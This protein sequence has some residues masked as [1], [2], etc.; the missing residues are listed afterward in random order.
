MLLGFLVL[1]A[2][3]GLAIWLQL[4]L[5]TGTAMTLI[6]VH[7]YTGLLGLPVLA[8]KAVAGA[9]SWRR[10]ATRPRTPPSGRLD[11]L[12]TA[13][14]VA[15]V[16]ALYGSGVTM[17]GNWGVL[18]GGTLK[19]VHLWAAVAGV[20]ILTYHLWRFLSRARA[21]VG[22]AIRSAEPV[23][24][25]G[26]RHLL[27][28]GGL[29]LVGWGAVR[30]GAGSVAELDRQGPNDFPVTL[31]S[32]GADQPDPATWRMRI[33]GEVQRPLV[34][35]LADLRAG[36][37]ERHRYSLDC[38]L[39]WSATRTWGG[40]PLRDLLRTAGASS[41]LISVVVRS[42]T[43]YRVALLREQVEDPR[44]MVAWEVDG[45]DLTP[46]HGHPARMMAPGVIGELCLKWV[47][48]VTVVAA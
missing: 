5:G 31:T 4:T 48:S 26:R 10:R 6:A 17:Y 7:A 44:T 18:P 20:P 8:V 12:M 25:T 45:V 9:V 46:E 19:L 40:V 23:V 1:G 38:V 41:D 14:L 37:V 3:S 32:G 36:A 30:V 13:A 28:A 21:T 11:H 24:A 42:T 39:G 29:A 2:G 33:D 15:V 34:L 16:L 35:S 22:Y 47:D 43:G 27:L